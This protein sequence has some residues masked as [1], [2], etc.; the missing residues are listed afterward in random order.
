M[1]DRMAGQ[2]LSWERVPED[3]NEPFALQTNEYDCGVFV[4]VYA[5]CIAKGMPLS[6]FAQSDIEYFRR[7]FFAEIFNGEVLEVSYS[8]S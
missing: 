6:S 8:H 4:I 1:L 7:K 5:L 2:R 3:D